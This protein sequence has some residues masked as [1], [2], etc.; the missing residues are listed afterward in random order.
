LTDVLVAV[1][2][3]E[4]APAESGKSAIQAVEKKNKV[5]VRAFISMNHIMELM[6]EKG[7]HE[8]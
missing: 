6:E 4:I 3:A 7:T 5:Q 1:D 8:N 2:H